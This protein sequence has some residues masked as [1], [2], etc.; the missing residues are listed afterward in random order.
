MEFQGV[1][2]LPP[3]LQSFLASL[4]MLDLLLKR[5]WVATHVQT[6]V[7]TLVY[8]ITIL[9]V[10]P[11]AMVFYYVGVLGIISTYTISIYRMHFLSNSFVTSAIPITEAIKSENFHLLLMA[12]LWLITPPQLFKLLPFAIFSTLNLAIYA[13]RNLWAPKN[14]F[15]LATAPLIEYAQHPMMMTVA[16][17]ELVLFLV[18]FIQGALR[19]SFY[20]YIMYFFI[21][22]LRVERSPYSRAVIYQFLNLITLALSQPNIPPHVFHNWILIYKRIA[23]I[24][25]LASSHR[26]RLFYNQNKTVWPTASHS[27][28]VNRGRRGKRRSHHNYEVYD[29]ADASSILQ[30]F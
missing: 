21:W 24:I 20:A 9:K 11:L 15:V 5:S 10:P 25:P 19:G 4:P 17:I 7:S 2:P 18:V 27:P 30:N 14:P 22:C 28:A 23:E 1:P 6:I 26:N 8:F 3:G 13:N 12:L 16:Y 29:H